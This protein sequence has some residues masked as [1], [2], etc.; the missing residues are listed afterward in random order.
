[1]SS[2]RSSHRALALGIAA[3]ACA[4]TCESWAASNRIAAR[5]N[6]EIITEGDLQAALEAVFAER[7]AYKA[8]P[9]QAQEARGA[10]LMQLI[11]HRLLIQEAKRLSITVSSSEVLEGWELIKRRAGSEAQYAQ[12]LR[13][14]QLS[15][16]QLKR[17]IHDQLL[18]RKVIDQEVRRTIQLTPAELAH[19]AAQAATAPEPTVPDGPDEAKILHMLL[20]IGPDRPV[21]VAKGQAEYLHQRLLDGATPEE[22]ATHSDNSKQPELL[23]QWV[24]QGQLMPQLDRVVFQLQ[25][26]EVSPPIQSQLGFHVIKVLERRR[27]SPPPPAPAPDPQELLYEKKFRDAMRTWLQK[28]KANAYI[29]IR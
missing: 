15:E 28:L 24:Q 17:K 6:D 14:S 19:A 12:L 10:V 2:T 18:A 23:A 21:D 25:A 11:E 1:M 5:V 16:E 22:L 29:E 8:N 26:G 9:Q 20:R 13:E 3:L 27:P 4:V 7:P